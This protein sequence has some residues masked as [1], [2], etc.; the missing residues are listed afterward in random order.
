[1]KTHVGSSVSGNT[2]VKEHLPPRC[3]CHY[4]RCRRPTILTSDALHLPFSPNHTSTS[5]R[6]SKGTER[7]AG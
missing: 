7:S 6:W 1:M 2:P 4:R 3:G 5:F